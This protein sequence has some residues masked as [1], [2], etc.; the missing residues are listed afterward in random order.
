MSAAA[1]ASSPSQQRRRPPPPLDPNAVAAFNAVVA[2]AAATTATA[3]SSSTT[4]GPSTSITTSSLAQQQQQAFFASNSSASSDSAADGGV[5]QQQAQP[6]DFGA[7][8]RTLSRG[9]FA[10]AAASSG[11]EYRDRDRDRDGVR[12]R[13]AGGDAGGVGRSDAEMRAGERRRDPSRGP[14]GEREERFRA[15]RE[16]AQSRERVGGER[17]NAGTDRDG[18]RDRSRDLADADGARRTTGP[19]ERDRS[20]ARNEDGRGLEKSRSESRRGGGGGAAIAD[21]M[22]DLD[23]F[24]VEDRAERTKV[25][26]P[27]PLS[28]TPSSSADPLPRQ[29]G[30][31]SRIQISARGSSRKINTLRAEDL[32]GARESGET[33]AN[34]AVS[35]SGTSSRSRSVERGRN[36]GSAS[37]STSGRLLGT[38]RERYGTLD[39]ARSARP[40]PILDED[41]RSALGFAYPQR[42][43]NGSQSSSSVTAFE[44][45]TVEPAAIVSMLPDALNDSKTYPVLPPERIEDRRREFAVLSSQVSSLQ[46]RLTLESR[47]REAALNLAKSTASG[48]R[49]QAKATQE[50]LSAANRKVDSIATELWKATGKLMEVER[51][52][53]KHTSA[54]L[55]FCVSKETD[56]T[57]GT[58]SPSVA[59]KVK[60]ESAETKVK[61]YEREISVLKS[62]ISRLETDFTDAKTEL[63]KEQETSRKAERAAADNDRIIRSL[64][65]ELKDLQLKAVAAESP[66]GT[67]EANR[68]KLDLATYRAEI[69]ANQE[70]LALARDRIEKQQA[71]MDELLQT[72]EEKD[73]IIANLLSEL[74]EVTN[75]LEMKSAA[76]D[77]LMSAGVA[78]PTLGSAQS[79]AVEKQ[80]RAQIAALEAELREATK[81]ISQ[82]GSRSSIILREKV[83]QQVNVQTE[84]VRSLLTKQLKDAIAER[85]KLK[86]Q[87]ASERSRAMDLEFEMDDLRDRAAKAESKSPAL[88]ATSRREFVSEGDMKALEQLHRDLPPLGGNSRSPARGGGGNPLEM[89]DLSTPFTVGSLV[90]KA[91]RVLSDT[92]DLARALDASSNDL[93]EAREGVEAAQRASDALQ[94]ELR[95]ARD[96]AAESARAAESAERDL[97]TQLRAA[98]RAVDRLREDLAEAEERGRQAE[99]LASLGS[100]AASRKVEQLQSA[101]AR[102]LAAAA[103]RADRRVAEAERTLADSVAAAEARVAEKDKELDEMRRF[104]E[105]EKAAV[106]ASEAILRDRLR[107]AEV[108]ARRDVEDAE[109]R[110][111]REL[112]SAIEVERSRSARLRD[113]LEKE[114][115][116]LERQLDEAT[117]AAEADAARRI[118]EVESRCQRDMQRKIEAAENEC[119]SQ[120]EDEREAFRAD[121]N[122]A[123]QAHGAELDRV[124]GQLSREHRQNMADLEAR[125]TSEKSALEKE[126]MMRAA[127]EAESLRSKHQAT[128]DQLQSRHDDEVRRLRDEY[129]RERD[130]L[131]GRVARAEATLLTVKGQFFEDR[132]KLNETIDRLNEKVRQLRQAEQDAVAATAAAQRDAD[133]TIDKLRDDLLSARADADRARDEASRNARDA[134]QAEQRHRQQLATVESECAARVAELEAHLEDFEAVRLELAS[135]ERDYIAELSKYDSEKMTMERSVKESREAQAALRSQLETLQKRLDQSQREVQ[136]ARSASARRDP[137]QDRAAQMEMERMQRTIVEL[138][139]SK[140]ELLQELDD[141]VLRF[142]AA[143]AE[144]SKIQREYEK[145]LRNVRD[146]DAERKRYETTLSSQRQEISTL[147]ARLQDLNVDRLGTTSSP[148]DTPSTQKLRAEFRKMVADLRNDYAGQ[149]QREAAT[150]SQLESQLRQA[151][152]QRDADLLNSHDLGT[153][154]VLKWVT[155]EDPQRIYYGV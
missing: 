42:K 69:S 77:A 59:D 104:V 68:I 88:G 96:D 114:I 105:S 131:K 71:A 121:L 32:R 19:R 141:Q 57:R 26:S 24:A 65:A 150:I 45:V 116:E 154:T 30:S 4:A 132:E 7:Y 86:S 18:G 143:Q 99:N 140:N 62:T 139:T 17:F 153:Q 152:R 126:L 108:R 93:R 120:L 75:M 98:E 107:D 149:L 142:Q 5:G 48:D 109:E 41:G 27:P 127:S 146:W 8:G 31:S 1:S 64:E 94:S 91:N 35:E 133:A 52:V 113:E 53:L 34:D 76:K 16:R 13:S 80:L 148:T 117:A 106:R 56:G 103:E 112:S 90:A 84:S 10:A 129:E 15:G 3:T 21:L 134:A 55:R 49:A 60:L 37:A 92:R 85:E 51:S 66:M 74:E 89:G 54:V 38:S 118:Q 79:S 119:R 137:E 9:R 73:R 122:A 155:G 100:S 11:S 29:G 43:R 125:L 40:T 82:G 47:I 138:K 36:E 50:Q 78:A 136:E 145:V 58:T 39:S 111:K 70:D 46:N 44:A 83:A 115:A 110:A 95:R 147:Q 123:E 101:H 144:S 22:K 124:R 135:V 20:M 6:T 28:T 61:E 130:D 102:E 33:T 67:T 25:E 23:S 72:V 151:S 81:A 87:L 97:R 12:G 128:V 14:A 63:S 2:A